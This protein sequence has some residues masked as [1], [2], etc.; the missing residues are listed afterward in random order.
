VELFHA[1]EKAEYKET[2]TKGVSNPTK[3]RREWQKD[4]NDWL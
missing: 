3:S 4:E 1:I 2:K